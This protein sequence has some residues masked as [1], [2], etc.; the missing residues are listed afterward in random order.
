MT[1]PKKKQK[2]VAKAVAKATAKTAQ[3]PAETGGVAG[4]L[5]ILVG[6]AAGIDD[7]D[8]LAAMGIVVGFIPAGITWLVN[9]VK[10]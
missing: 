7:P 6:K 3:R 9:L 10:A 5:V 4:A 1:T 8:A 2:P